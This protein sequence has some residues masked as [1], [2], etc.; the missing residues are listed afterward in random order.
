[1]SS[2]QVQTVSYIRNSQTY[3]SETEVEQALNLTVRG[4]DTC[5]KA[6]YVL[7]RV[8]NMYSA[9]HHIPR[10]LILIAGFVTV[11]CASFRTLTS[12]LRI[13]MQQLKRE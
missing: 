4:T 6:V 12:C 2:I 9:I 1:M 11:G 3:L 7:V 5:P 13:S 8:S 10:T